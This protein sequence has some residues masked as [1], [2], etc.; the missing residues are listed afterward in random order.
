M[1]FLA[2]MIWSFRVPQI[3]EFPNV[4]RH[5]GSLFKYPINLT[6]D[7]AIV[8]E[9]AGAGTRQWRRSFAENSLRM[10]RD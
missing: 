10:A 7:A 5:W 9:V 6:E 3:K 2:I 8:P 1:V 4:N